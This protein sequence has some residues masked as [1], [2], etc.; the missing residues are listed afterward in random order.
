MNDNDKR[1][2]S[3]LL[4]DKG[5]RYRIVIDNDSVWVE[6]K[7]NGIIVYDFEEYGYHLLHQVLNE[8]GIEA[9]L[10]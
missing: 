8:F 1:I 4:A 10:C 3:I 2:L 6:D 7:N 5:K 9:K